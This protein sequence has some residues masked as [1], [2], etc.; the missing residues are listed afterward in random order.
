M[1][2]LKKKKYGMLSLYE[3]YYLKKI[4][5]FLRE[6]AKRIYTHHVGVEVEFMILL[7][8]LEDLFICSNQYNFDKNQ[9]KFFV[10]HIEINKLGYPISI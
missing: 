5:F 4:S 6:N 9:I 10:V 2:I 3:G 7:K 1:A 8:F